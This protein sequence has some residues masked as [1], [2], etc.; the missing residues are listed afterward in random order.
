[1][2]THG[3]ARASGYPS[4]AS[5]SNSAFIPEVWSGK[6]TTKFYATTVFGEIAI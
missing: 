6:L 5:D 1:M 2:A 3:P 4:Y